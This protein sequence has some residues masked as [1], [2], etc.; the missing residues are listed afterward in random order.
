MGLMLASLL[1]AAGRTVT[2]ADRHRERRV[3]A[4]ALGAT[5]VETLATHPLVFEAIGRPRTWSLALQAAAPGGTVV[6]VGGCPRGTMLKVPTTPL[7]YDELDLRGSF[8]HSP[9]DV[10][11][12]LEALAH[13]VVDWEALLGETIPLEQLPAA[14]ARAGN[15]RA[16]KHVVDP[17][18]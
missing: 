6:F 3:Q 18:L 7:H 11:R 12:A 4:D 13:G 5:G 8:H 15:G 1:L 9:G 10:E 14:L 16:R 2:V 17:R